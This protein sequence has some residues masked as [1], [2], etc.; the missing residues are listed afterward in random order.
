MASCSF[1]KRRNILSSPTISNPCLIIGE[2]LQK[3]AEAINFLKENGIISGYSD[4]TFKP[5]NPLNRA[6][7]LKILVEG[8]GYSPDENVYKNCFSDVKEDWYAKYVC[9]AKEQ[10]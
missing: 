3:D 1:L 5:T 7:L 6:E 9:Y 4:G 2:T 8:V 10:G